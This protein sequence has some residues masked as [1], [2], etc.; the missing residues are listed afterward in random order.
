MIICIILVVTLFS[1]CG[2]VGSESESE[3]V[4]NCN[5][6]KEIREAVE[7]SAKTPSASDTVYSRDMKNIRLILGEGQE[8]RISEKSA[9]SVYNCENGGKLYILF[10]D[11][12][13]DYEAIDCAVFSLKN[14]SRKDFD[15]LQVNKSDFADVKKLDPAAEINFIDYGNEKFSSHFTRD[16]VITINYEEADDSL[17]VKSVDINY[18]DFAVAVLE[19]DLPKVK[20]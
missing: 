2:T 9:Y 5:T 3:N 15:K 20:A 11:K 4:N 18:E 10:D 1:A 6:V 19:E 16:G 12:T 8:R 14:L 17:T 7:Y 13:L